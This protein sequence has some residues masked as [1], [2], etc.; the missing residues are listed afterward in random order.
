MA[1]YLLSPYTQRVASKRIGVLTSGGD[2]PGLNAVLHG[3]VSAATTRGYEVLG[4]L[5]GYEGL[6]NPVRYQRLDPVSVS[7]ISHLG[8][9]ILGTTNRGRFVAKVGA[10]KKAEID[11]AILKQ[12]RDTCRG[13]NLHA[14]ICIGGDGS[15]ST[16]LQLQKAGVNVVGVP[17]TIDNDIL[18]TATSFGFDSAVTC[19]V[20]GL[21]R[22]HTTARS[23]KRI[24]VVETMGRHA[25]WIALQ[26][27]LAGGADVILIP[28]IPFHYAK[29]AAF[30]KERAAQGLPSTMIVVAEGAIPAKGQLS[31]IQSGLRGKGEVRLGG[32]G[33]QV[34]HEMEKRT[35]QET[36]HVVL[37]HLQRGGNPTALDRILG[38][39]F[40]VGAVEL[41]VKKKFGQMV[42]YQNYEI[43]GVP[44]ADA[45]A[46]IRTVPPRGQ[47][48]HHAREIGICFGD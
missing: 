42:S 10:G 35:E 37:G 19:V 33:G 9:T 32:I 21:D 17:K 16:S 36:R 3:V 5:D 12:A 41:V 11:P 22:L 2:C 44:I 30:A 6:L 13:L 7:H 46:R 27:G 24:M 14:L 39:R 4:F 23:H 28:E 26:G 18:A 47:F 34:A 38:T 48:V 31:T 20:D 25:G 8:G 1:T 45:V 40:G 29:V 15:L 43:G